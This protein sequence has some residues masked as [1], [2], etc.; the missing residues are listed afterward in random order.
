MEKIAQVHEQLSE[1]SDAYNSED[2]EPEDTD[3]LNESIDNELVESQILNDAQS[4]QESSAGTQS[5]QND[6][7]LA[8]LAQKTQ[9]GDALRKQV[10][11]GI[12]EIKNLKDVVQQKELTFNE[13]LAELEKRKSA[14]LLPFYFSYL[15]VILSHI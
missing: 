5:A 1:N 10:A 12:E 14:Y 4:T 9:E 2:D 7:L 8:Q 6:A 13:L 11:E 15:V 3:P